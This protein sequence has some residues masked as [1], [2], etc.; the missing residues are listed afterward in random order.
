MSFKTIFVYMNRDMCDRISETLPK[1]DDVWLSSVGLEDLKRLALLVQ[2]NTLR[3][4]EIHYAG[5]FEIEYIP[6]KSQVL[7]EADAPY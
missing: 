7:E 6:H 1:E 4:K 2:G 3:L 5:V